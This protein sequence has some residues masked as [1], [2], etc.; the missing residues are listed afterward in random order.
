VVLLLGQKLQQAGHVTTT[1]A[2]VAWGTR[3]QENKNTGVQ[4][5]R[6]TEVQENS[7]KK[8]ALDAKNKD[9]KR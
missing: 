7:E 5:Y 2:A 4:E 8:T 6:S 1:M 9:P 3:E